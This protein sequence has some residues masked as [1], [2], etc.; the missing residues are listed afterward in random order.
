LAHDNEG[1]NAMSAYLCNTQ[2]I[3]ALAA[4]ATTTF[5]KYAG[6]GHICAL[7]DWR[8][9]S[10]TETAMRVAAE[11]AEQNI[12]SLAA[13][14][15]SDTS[16]NRPGPSGITDD[17]YVAD[18]RDFAREYLR[19]PTGLKPLDIISMCKCYEYQACESDDWVETKAHTQIQWIIDEAFRQIPGYDDAVRDYCGKIERRAA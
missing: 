5:S 8:G 11:L 4:F 15:P 9:G 14:Y 10:N 2:H 18:C 17:Q 3:G 16:G 7:H 19:R 13:R 12:A 6:G 1:E